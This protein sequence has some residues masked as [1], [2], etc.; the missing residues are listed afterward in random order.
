MAPR[1]GAR[2]T[3]ATRPKPS[4]RNVAFAVIRD[5]FGEPRRGAHES[6]DYH[7]RRSDLDARDRAFVTELA[8][9]T[10]RRRRWLDWQL[11]P[12][13]AG[14]ALPQMISEIL[15]MGAY[16]LRV[17][18]V[19]DY[20]AVSESVQ[21]ARRFGHAGTAG[22][23]NAVLRRVSTDPE[24]PVL[25]S[26]FEDPDDVLGTQ[27]SLPTWIVRSWRE[28][29]GDEKLAAICAGVDGSPALGL[30]VDLRVAT[31][32]A[33]ASLLDA[34]G[35][36]TH[37][38]PFARD[39]LIAET[40]APLA[41]LE[42]IV[43][44]R[45]SIH[46]E[47]ACLPVDILDPQPGERIFEACSG[48]GNKT[49][50][51]VSRMDDRGTIA[52]IDLDARKIAVARERLARA[53]ATIATVELGDASIATGTDD[54]DR[55]LVDAPCSGLG[56][57]GRQPEARWRKDA[58]DAAR[59]A[60]AQ[61]AILAAAA[62]R[63]RPGGALVYAVCST[64][65]RESDDV[66]EAFLAATPAFARSPIDARYAEFLSPAGDVVVPPGIA[67]RDGFFIARLQRR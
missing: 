35:I 37:P 10:I 29:F 21:L 39:V 13:V 36:A 60:P 55:V 2:V 53:G 33:V 23:V 66:V 22:L 59:L 63:V 1:G 64:D 50:Q 18:R 27:L 54:C 16:Q 41:D 28:R 44:E 12:Y 5:V 46:A 56:I 8:Y 38:S 48:R 25:A 42:R 6:L 19:H 11:A 43:G 20:A 14:R 9:G 52:G 58:A 30:C 26:D 67:G 17:M 15:R 49:L 34:A 45:V 61:A 32:D 57:I 31:R 4:A 24:R 7:L 3:T 62:T 51:L 65:R 40:N 47:S